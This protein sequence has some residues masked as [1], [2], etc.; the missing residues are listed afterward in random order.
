MEKLLTTTT[1]LERLGYDEHLETVVRH[2][3]NLDEE[4]LLDGNLYLQGYGDPSF[5]TG[6]LALLAS[7]AREADQM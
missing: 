3:G 2:D 5:E 7:Q 6:D 4:G 1:S